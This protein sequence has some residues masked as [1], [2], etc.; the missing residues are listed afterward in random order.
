MFASLFFIPSIKTEKLYRYSGRK[1]ILS[2]AEI[3]I[4]G[5]HHLFAPIV[6]I[7]LIHFFRSLVAIKFSSLK[8]LRVRQDQ[9]DR[10]LVKSDQLS[11]L[12]DYRCSVFQFETCSHITASSQFISFT[13]RLSSLILAYIYLML[14]CLRDKVSQTAV[15]DHRIIKTGIH[16]RYLFCS[17]VHP[18]I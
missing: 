15:F 12:N 18:E 14:F 11:D 4:T 8:T 3:Q 10:S 5:T 13:K 2:P 9:A 17:C 7:S 1:Y 16:R 6:V